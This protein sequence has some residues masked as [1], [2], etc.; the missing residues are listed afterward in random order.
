MT[1]VSPDQVKFLVFDTE[2]VPDG[3]LISRVKYPG[4]NLDPEAAVDRAQ[5][6]AREESF[7]GSDFLPFLFHRPVCLG[8]AK[9]AQDYS[10]L[11][12][13]VLNSSPENVCSL[14]WSGMGGVYSHATLVSFNGRGF[15]L[16]LLEMA[17]YRYAV[18]APA[19]FAGRESI[20]YRY[21]RQHIDLQE[22]F[23]NHGAVR[24]PGG[25]DAVAKMIGCPGKIDVKGSDVLLMHRS[26]DHAGIAGYCLCDVLDT[27]R[28]FLRTRIMFGELDREGEV[29]LLQQAHAVVKEHAP[30]WPAL[31]KYLDRWES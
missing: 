9:V 22:L 5:S 21:S 28:V 7:R 3:D 4:Q 31:H 17:A 29:A 6:E 25:L 12:L 10:L 24:L 2:T 13:T 30:I 11:G 20:R 1:T 14:W 23:T 27:Y 15:D 19:H 8:M 18:P 26:G 16:P